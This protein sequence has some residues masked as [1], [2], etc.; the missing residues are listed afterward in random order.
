[1]I[2]Y[3]YRGATG[4]HSSRSEADEKRDAFVLN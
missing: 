4:C 2:Q 1:M 3:V